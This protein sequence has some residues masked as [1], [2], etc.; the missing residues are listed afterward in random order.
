M[1]SFE[2]GEENEQVFQY[3]QNGNL[4]FTLE[5]LN[6]ENSDEFA[7]PLKELFEQ[8]VDHYQENIYTSVILNQAFQF[9]ILD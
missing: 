3:L 9:Q 5:T 1:I 7:L 6:R 2:L 4:I 8:N